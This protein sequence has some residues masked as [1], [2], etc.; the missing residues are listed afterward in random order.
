MRHHEPRVQEVIEHVQGALRVLGDGKIVWS[1]RE[2]W[3]GYA[4]RLRMKTYSAGF[5]I[6]R[7][8]LEDP[9]FKVAKNWE[10][11]KWQI[12]YGVLRKMIDDSKPVEAK[13]VE[14]IDLNPERTTL[15]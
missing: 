5:E 2:E 7:I 14:F 6:S 1:V 8:A 15:A 4:V 3:R 11:L 9:V 13:D 12:T 10:S